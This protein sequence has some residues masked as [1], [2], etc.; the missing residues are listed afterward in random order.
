MF[1]PQN[2]ETN[3]DGTRTP[4]ARGKV[5][6]DCGRKVWPFV[7]VKTTQFDNVP[8]DWACDACWATWQRTRKPLMMVDNSPDLW[9]TDHKKSRQAWDEQWLTGHGAPQEVIN[10]MK[11]TNRRA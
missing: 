4:D 3:P 1:S 9:H 6:C 10:T 7:L 5:A 8:N 11:Q 2:Y